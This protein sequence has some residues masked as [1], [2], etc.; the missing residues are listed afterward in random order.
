[1]GSVSYLWCVCHT[2]YLVYVN[3]HTL[4]IPHAARVVLPSR[5]CQRHASAHLAAAPPA[6]IAHGPAHGG[7]RLDHL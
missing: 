1:M 3:V 6:P 7:S 2:C 4:D 5:P